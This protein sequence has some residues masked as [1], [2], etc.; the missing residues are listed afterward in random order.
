MLSFTVH[1][2]AGWRQQILCTPENILSMW[3][4]TGNLALKLMGHRL[5][6]KKN[7]I[8][9]AEA[10]DKLNNIM[11]KLTVPWAVKLT[12]GHFQQC[13]SRPAQISFLSNYQV[14]CSSEPN[15]KLE[16]SCHDREVIH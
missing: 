11:G 2:Q 13:Y 1:S 4:V 6:L 8:I 15:K 10:Q 9:W 16:N 12:A 7:R 14:Q 3:S 5:Q